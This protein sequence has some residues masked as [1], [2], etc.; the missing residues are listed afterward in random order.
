MNLNDPPATIDA[1]IAAFPGPVR[2]RLSE[3]RR[4]LQE[5]IPDAREKISYGIPTLHRKRNIAHFA[6][7][8]HH[9]GFYPGASSIAAFRAE[10]TD[11]VHAKGSVQFPHDRA[12]PIDLIRRMARFASDEEHTRAA[13]KGKA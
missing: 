9:L 7:Y 12:L 5:E 2:D 11:Y 4:V 13:K 3:I 1:Y 10:L 8:A 6:G